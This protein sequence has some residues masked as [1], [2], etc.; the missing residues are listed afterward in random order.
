MINEKIKYNNKLELSLSALMFFSPL[1]QK[2]IK[3]RSDISKDE[4]NFI[5]WFIKIWYMNILML[6]L[7]I[8]LQIIFYLT[9]IGFIQSISIIT[10]TILA[11]SLVI[12]SIYAISGKELIKSNQIVNE[13]NSS[14]KK[15]NI[16]INY[17]P[18]YNIYLRY[19]KHNFENPDLVLKESILVWSTLLVTLLLFN[20]EKII[21]FGITIIVIRV[22]TLLNNIN[23]WEK[24][25][26]FVNSLF[27]KNP[28]EIRWYVIW[29]IKTIFNKK[30]LKEN[31]NTNKTIFE[32][33]IKIEYKQIL[34][35]Y[36]LLF[37]LGLYLIYYWYIN[38]NIS[39]LFSIVFILGRYVVMIIKWKRVPHLPII[40]EITSLF[41][42]NKNK[43]WNQ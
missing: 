36:I 6:I 9:N 32:L 25:K 27:K 43:I 2:Q 33:I 18:L 28:E 42:N 3:K 29:T 30:S 26:N 37:I 15:I 38:Q 35:E 31:I 24:T 4:K 17:I 34:L 16:I 11:I 8:W 41:F 7:S 10:T 14:Q 20:N 23:F 39:L 13:I 40:K 12:W 5:Q 19:K 22:I 1:I 21:W